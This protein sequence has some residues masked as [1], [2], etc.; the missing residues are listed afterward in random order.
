M[1]LR[2]KQATRKPEI[3]CESRVNPAYR[4]APTMRGWH[5]TSALEQGWHPG[6]GLATW[7]RARL[8]VTD[9]AGS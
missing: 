7:R 5:K 2:K 3:R 6:A 4:A 9:E 8:A 1:V